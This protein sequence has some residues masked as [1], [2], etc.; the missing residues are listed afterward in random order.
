MSQFMSD[1]IMG[2]IFLALGQARL[3]DY[4]ATAIGSRPGA[5]HPD[6]ASVAR[7][8]IIQR[9]SKARIVQEVGEYRVGQPLQHRY[10]TKN[11]ALKFHRSLDVAP[12]VSVLSGTGFGH[13]TTT[14]PKAAAPPQEGRTQIAIIPRSPTV[15]KAISERDFQAISPRWRLAASGDGCHAVLAYFTI[16]LTSG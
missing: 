1:D 16:R 10:D 3:E 6:R 4:A 8:V 5:R 2:E 9:Q 12:E 15:G 14:L 7:N 11:Q 13:S